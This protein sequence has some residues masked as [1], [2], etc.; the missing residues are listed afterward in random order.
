M[1]KIKQTNQTNILEN[2]KIGTSY[3]GLVNKTVVTLLCGFTLSWI[4]QV[5]QIRQLT[6]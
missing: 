5:Q 3:V 4:Y 1:Q 2:K 6:H